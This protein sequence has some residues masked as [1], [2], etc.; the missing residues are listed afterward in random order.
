MNREIKFR[1]QDIRGEWHIG[2]LT[3]IKDKWLNVASGSY[4]SNS[5][6]FFLPFAYAVRPETVGQYLG[7]ND[8]KGSELFEGAIVKCVLNLKVGERKGSGKSRGNS[9]SVNEDIE[10]IGKVVYMPK[11]AAYWFV[12]DYSHS[13]FS[14]SYKGCGNTLA[15]KRANEYRQLTDN[16]SRSLSSVIH[17]IEIIGN[18]HE[19]T[20]LL[21]NGN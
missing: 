16:V 15:E 4:I 9:Y 13:H 19:H 12:T 11:L 2:N 5:A 18:I 7:V 3:V 14:S 1:G 10:V 20:E 6:G 17:K 21:A 8:T